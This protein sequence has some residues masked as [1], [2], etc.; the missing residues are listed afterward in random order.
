MAVDVIL[1]QMEES[2]WTPLATAFG[3]TL[4]AIPDLIFAVVVLLIGYLIAHIVGSLIERVLIKVKFDKWVLEK[5]RLRIHVGAVKLSELFALI[6]K[7]YVFILF[8]PPAA[9][10]IK[11][12][13]LAGFLMKL[14]EWIPQLI[15]AIIIGLIGF[16]AADYI[17]NKVRQTKAKGCRPLASLARAVVLI[18][19]ILLVLDQIGVEISIAK[20]S[21]LIILAGISLG[22][23][24][25]FGLGLKDE[26]KKWMQG[27]RAKLR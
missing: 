25:A 16:I 10:I 11:L 3:R 22:F 12:E 18:F 14:A 1:H 7:W 23:A 17:A 19:T 13:P 20:N 15:L 27:I 4:T 5:T 9:N 8:L 6:A 2:V 21:F 24:L 26:A